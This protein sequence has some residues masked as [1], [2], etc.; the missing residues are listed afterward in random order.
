MS[1]ANRL[2]VFGSLFGVQGLGEDS[3]D[4]AVR[5]SVGKRIGA[6]EDPGSA[7][8]EYR[9]TGKA[10]APTFDPASGASQEYAAVSKLA[11]PDIKGIQDLI[12]SHN[13]WLGPQNRVELSSRMQALSA[14]MKSL[15]VS[16]RTQALIESEMKMAAQK[17]LKENGVAFQAAGS[18]AAR[19]ELGL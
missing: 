5:E 13:W 6:A 10:P 16:P 19:S 11:E 12:T 9:T 7:L 18:D 3:I 15:G 14:K 17:S 4:A 2:K 8:A 1:E